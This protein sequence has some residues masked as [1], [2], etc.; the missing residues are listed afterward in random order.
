MLDL[1]P[2]GHS[3]IAMVVGF[4]LFGYRCISYIEQKKYDPFTS[5]RQYK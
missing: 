3:Q 4:F 5:L 1:T 2:K